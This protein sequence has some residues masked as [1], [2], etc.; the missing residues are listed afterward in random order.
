MV[1]GW[2]QIAVDLNAFL[3][4][5]NPK[6]TGGFFVTHE[7]QVCQILKQLLESEK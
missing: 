5:E 1:P 2:L 6:N 4:K 7:I 3:K